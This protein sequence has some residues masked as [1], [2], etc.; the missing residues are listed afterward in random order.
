MPTLHN[1]GSLN[2]DWVYHVPGVVR[3]GQT[4]GASRRERF[5]GGKGANQSVAA[6]RAGQR[7]RHVGRV[8]D[9][10]AWLVELLR[11]EGVDTGHL[12]IDPDTPTGHAVIQVDPSGEN[13]IFLLPGANHR[14]DPGQ[15][16]A[17]L[18]DADG[19]DWVLSQNETGNA[20]Q[21]VAAAADRGLRCALNPAP[22]TD[23]LRDLPLDTLGLLVVNE[24]E[25]RAFAPPGEPEPV[26]RGLGRRVAGLAVL[27]LGAAGAVASD[28]QRFWS[29]PGRRVARVRDTTCAGDTFTGYL[30]AGLMAERDV[31]DALEHAVAAAALAVTR[32]GAIPSIPTAEETARFSAQR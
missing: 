7:V 27:T 17:A 31:R 23:G 2:I 11:R 30:I 26:V 6:A 28:G 32:D 15:I 8:G 16:D 29:I 1:I 5:A 9:D 20:R 25:S 21:V 3:P 10:G 13:A 22:I 18:R 12:V 4:L 19:D 24:T 14:I